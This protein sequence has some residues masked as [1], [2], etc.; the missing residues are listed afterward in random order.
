MKGEYVYV[1]RGGVVPPSAPLYHGPYKVLEA[2]K[3]FFTISLRGREDTISVDRLKHHLGGPV[4]P[5]APPPAKDRPPNVEITA[6]SI[7]SRPLLGGAPVED[8][9]YNV[10]NPMLCYVIPHCVVRGNPP[11]I[12]NPVVVVLGGFYMPVCYEPSY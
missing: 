4:V 3:K 5:A 1:S 7:I 8:S 2:G 11:N 10:R 9:L 6:A 12:L